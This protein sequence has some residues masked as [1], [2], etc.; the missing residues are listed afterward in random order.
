MEAEYMAGILLKYDKNNQDMLDYDRSILEPTSSPVETKKP[1]ASSA[2]V[3]GDD[4]STAGSTDS[5]ANATETV[6]ADVIM[7][8]GG[9]R[10]KQQQ[11]QLK[12]SYDS[13]YATISAHKGKKLF[14]VKFLVKNTSGASKRVNMM[15]RSLSYSL[16]IDG[17]SAGGP[18]MTIL[19][20]DLQYIDYSLENGKSREAVLVF[21]VDSSQKV[22][23]AVLNVTEGS[24]TAQLNLQ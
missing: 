13:S 3:T 24:K 4:L 14:V 19:D 15:K 22:K 8:K 9:I 16:E 10:I 1:T 6:K 17:T 11:Y 7:S 23:N 20:N 2:P 5:Q 12:S 21:E 18:L